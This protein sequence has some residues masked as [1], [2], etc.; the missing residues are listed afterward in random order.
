M[1]EYSQKHAMKDYVDFK[2]LGMLSGSGVIMSTSNKPILTVDGFKGVKLRS[3]SPSACGFA[4]GDVGR[5][6]DRR[7]AGRRGH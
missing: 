6:L 1:W 2:L 3:P 7:G 4:S 5:L